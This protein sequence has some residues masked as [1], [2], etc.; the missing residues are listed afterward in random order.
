MS[1]TPSEFI[2]HGERPTEELYIEL[3]DLEAMETRMTDE[4][5]TPEATSVVAT[6][7]TSGIRERIAHLRAL[8]SDR[9]VVQD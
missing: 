1:D 5:G 8:L 3:R 9:G 4:N 7:D 6:D 2:D